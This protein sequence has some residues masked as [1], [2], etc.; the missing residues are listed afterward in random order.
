M[1][2]LCE[3]VAAIEKDFR[4]WKD[5]IDPPPGEGQSGQATNGSAA[6]QGSEPAAG[7]TTAEGAQ[8]DEM[9][10]VRLEF[11]ALAAEVRSTYV[12]FLVKGGSAILMR[13]AISSSVIGGGGCERVAYIYSVPSSWDQ[14][15]PAEGETDKRRYRPVALWKDD[16]EQFVRVVS[17]LVTNATESVIGILVGKGKRQG[18]GL[19]V[20]AGCAVIQSVLQ[21]FADNQIK[22]SGKWRVKSITMQVPQGQPGGR[23]VGISG[24]MC[25]TVMFFWRGSWPSRMSPRPRPTLGGSTWDDVWRPADGPAG[26]LEVPYSIKEVIMEEAWASVAAARA[27][28]SSSKVA[29]TGSDSAEV[30]DDVVAPMNDDDDGERRDKKQ[31]AKGKKKPKKETKRKNAKKDSKK[32]KKE[33]NKSKKDAKMDDGTNDGEKAKGGKKANA[34]GGKNADAK[35]KKKSGSRKRSR[36]T[37][38]NKAPLPTPDYMKVSPQDLQESMKSAEPLFH[39]DYAESVW[40]G[41]FREFQSQAALVW[42]M[43]N[44]S[45]GFAAI[46]REILLLGIAM[47]DTHLS[48]VKR[49]LDA[50]IT[51]ATQASDTERCTTPKLVA[52]GA[53]WKR[54]AETAETDDDE[55]GQR[56][57]RQGGGRRRRRRRR[58][59]RRRGGGGGGEEA[60]DEDVRGEAG[61]KKGRQTWQ[62]PEDVGAPRQWG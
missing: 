6:G 18:A 52:V 44:G 11:A 45:P 42:T 25:E 17:P 5:G 47:N 4:S 55:G 50:R 30:D 62:K 35:Q 28:R 40:E 57:R 56:R 36:I 19:F 33:K 51:I 13:A 46:L 22:A 60:T 38:I 10:Q 58:R 59:G 39:I 15:R 37:D 14:M 21:V 23:I 54:L 49:Y 12:G 8:D 2:P 24:S 16:L 29:D 26:A 43:G 41:M 61:E 34:K 3:E 1:P 32:H 20:E 27:A 31:K 48:V 7:Q 9:A 53:D